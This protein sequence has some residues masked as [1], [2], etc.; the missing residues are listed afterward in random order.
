MNQII[1]ICI[2]C[3]LII[4]III[5]FMCY[6]INCMHNKEDFT[7][8]EKEITEIENLLKLQCNK[9]IQKEISQFK[10]LSGDIN[11]RL[12]Q[13][14]NENSSQSAYVTIDNRGKYTIKTENKVH[15]EILDKILVKLSAKYQLPK[16][17]FVQFFGDQ[18][19]H[20]G[21]PVLQNSVQNYGLM[22]P[23]WYWY[24]KDKI[25]SLLLIPWR[26]RITRAIWRGATTGRSW[27]RFRSRRYIV[28]SSFVFPN[29][30]DARFVRN[31]QGVELS[32]D[33]FGDFLRNS[34]QQKYKYLV[35]KDGNGGT[36]GLY[37]QLVSGCCLILNTSHKQWF[38]DFFKK[39]ID[40][41]E[42]DD[43]PENENLIQ[44]LENLDPSRARCIAENSKNVGSILFNE[45]FCLWYYYQLILELSQLY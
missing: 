21:L 13:F 9:Q 26:E 34:D 35:S 18:Q 14:Y 6:Y 1:T 3:L 17:Q 27:D 22:S 2:C 20:N 40:Y 23:F 30:L 8:N 41:L 29:L 5:I 11:Q 16:C 42:Y 32:R 7:E 25:N 38:S 33:Y 45:E 12:L 19:K 4:L 39:G 37:W 28:D 44:I 24:S 36:Y 31:G 15:G 10:N 43:T